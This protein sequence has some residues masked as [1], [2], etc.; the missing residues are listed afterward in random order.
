MPLKRQ[1]LTPSTFSFTDYT[2]MHQHHVLCILLRVPQKKQLYGTRRLFTLDINVLSDPITC[3]LLSVQLC[4]PQDV[5][6]THLRSDRS[7]Y[8]WKWSRSHVTSQHSAV[9]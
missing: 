3:G 7:D 5:L 6:M 4:T 9:V 2:D 8:I 1:M